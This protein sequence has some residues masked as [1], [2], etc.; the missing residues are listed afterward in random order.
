[1]RKETGYDLSTGTYWKTLLIEPKGLSLGIVDYG[2]IGRR[3]GHTQGQ[4][5]DSSDDCGECEIIL[6]G[7]PIH[8]VNPRSD[9]ESL[10]SSAWPGQRG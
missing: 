5:S 9:A 4:D 6:H 3:V 10:A 8:V 2:R 7:S 1:M